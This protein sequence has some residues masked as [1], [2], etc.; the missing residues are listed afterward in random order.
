MLR[1]KIPNPNS[2]RVFRHEK[3]VSFRRWDAAVR[4]EV[5]S[6]YLLGYV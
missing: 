3:N 5:C 6:S 4:A 2:L 1:P